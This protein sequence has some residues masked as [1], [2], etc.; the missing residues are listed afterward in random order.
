MLE[1][2]RKRLVTVM[3]RHRG[4]RQFHPNTTAE[5]PFAPQFSEPGWSMTAGGFRPS[6]SLRREN[7]NADEAAQA[8][9]NRRE[10]APLRRSERCSWD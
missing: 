9:P 6:R 10:R 4:G 3:A 2:L 8:V 5:G 1:V 7:L